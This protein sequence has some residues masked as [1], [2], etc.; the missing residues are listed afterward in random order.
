MS[1][2]P[3]VH[4]EFSSRDRGESIQF[5]G[6]VFGWK[7]QDMPE[8]NYATF[9]PGSPP[10]G[11]FNPTSDQVK[12]G[13]VIVYVGTDDIEATL[14]KVESAGGKTIMPK[15]EI[16]D[17]GWFALFADPTGNIIGLFSGME[18]QS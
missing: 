3:I 7:T 6:K 10:G 17:T 16:S 15:T 2:H 4:I 5:F 18:G 13:D 9:D 11:G 14:A 12:A 1:E 8:M